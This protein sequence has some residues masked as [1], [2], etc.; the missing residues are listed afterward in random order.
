[1]PASRSRGLVAATVLLVPLAVVAAF[2][3]YGGRHRI[4]G[5]GDP[6][7]PEAVA[8]GTVSS[9]LDGLAE[10]TAD[11]PPERFHEQVDGAAEF[12]IGIGATRIVAWRFEGP[13]EATL[14]LLEFRA[15]E[16]ARRALEQDTGGDRT[17]GP[18]DEAWAGT[19]SVLFRRGRRYVRLSAPGA[20]GPDAA[21]QLAGLAAR[22]D[23]RLRGLTAAGGG[24]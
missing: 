3:A 24:S 22:V 7:A 10:R 11:L 14:E 13:P 21:A 1:M 9:L 17:P 4:F 8:A 5:P 19:D 18:G 15:D 12:L 16:G 6:D 2:L 20:S 23:E